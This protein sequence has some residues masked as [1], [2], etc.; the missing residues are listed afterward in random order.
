VGGGPGQRWKEIRH[1]QSV[2]WLAFWN[3]PINNKDFKSFS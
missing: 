1:D 2:T 3:D